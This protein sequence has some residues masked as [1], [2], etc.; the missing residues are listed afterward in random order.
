MQQSILVGVDATLSLPTQ[1]A[2][3]VVCQHIAQVQAASQLLLLHVIPVPLDPTLRWGKSLR[4][5]SYVPPTHEQIRQ[6]RQVLLRAHA[7]LVQRGIP[8]VSIEL[9]L[10]A[11]AP[12]E[13][14]DLVAREHHVDLLVLGSHP[15]SHLRFLH[16]VLFGS[17]SHRI[18]QLA[19]CRVLLTRLPASFNSDR[20]SDRYEQAVQC[21]LQQQPEKM[22][23][24]T[25][26]DVACRFALTDQM[27]GQKE[28][29]AA[30]CA[31]KRLSDRGL[32]LCQE[33]QG[34]M[35]CCND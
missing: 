22:L 24:F 4:D 12:A 29:E 34:E 6:A 5:R 20:L 27:I 10:R 1:Y 2:L 13:E 18:L 9:L 30:T 21:L 35:R 15:P 16:R 19:L 11:G 25:P 8:P 32:I 14:L 23:I 17:I 33:V 3:E 7:F 26:T 28:V 31:L